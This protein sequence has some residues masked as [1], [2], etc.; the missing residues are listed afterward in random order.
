MAS[1]LRTDKEITQIYNR[2]V[3]TVF[4]VC[5]SFMKN[6]PE[7][8]DM[9]QETFLRLITSGK[10]FENERHEKAWLIVTAS[11]LCK[12]TLKRWWRREES[13][14]ENPALAQ[15]TADSDNDLLEAILALPR[16][17]K[18][19][20]YM[21]YYEGYTALEIAQSLRCPHATV[22]TRLARARKLLKSMLGGESDETTEHSGCL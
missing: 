14:E 1:L 19:A 11:N 2:H 4:Y 21:Y 16:D 15:K 12:D 10:T 22:R 6:K 5:Y 3:D 20:V 18:T 8:E 9:V 7:A 13:I 17:Y